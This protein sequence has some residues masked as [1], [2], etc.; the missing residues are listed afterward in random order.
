MSAE[1]AR[2]ERKRDAGHDPQSLSHWPR[3][4][5]GISLCQ[6]KNKKP[7]QESRRRVQSTGAQRR[8]AGREASRQQEHRP[9][10]PDSLLPGTARHGVAEKPCFFSGAAPAFAS[11]RHLLWLCGGRVAW[12]LPRFIFTWPR[13][14]VRTRRF[15]VRS[16]AAAGCLAAVPC[17]V[18]LV[19]IKKKTRRRLRVRLREM[20][21]CTWDLA[22]VGRRPP[23]GS[24]DS[25]P[26]TVAR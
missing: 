26:S 20:T 5:T 25:V 17:G 4:S 1:Q 7:L 11:R 18:V 23:S 9:P 15:L 24:D 19:G 10:F 6:N 16:H 14:I 13:F 8:S 12:H 3:I 2:P 22:C 21:K